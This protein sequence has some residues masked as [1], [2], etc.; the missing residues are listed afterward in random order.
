MM[1]KGG[2][3]YTWIFF[4]ECSFLD[5][6]ICDTI[7]QEAVDKFPA[8]NDFDKRHYYVAEKFHACEE[9]R[10]KALREKEKKS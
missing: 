3:C 6:D 2:Q 5:N 7:I 1:T 4:D 8:E 9:E 10:L